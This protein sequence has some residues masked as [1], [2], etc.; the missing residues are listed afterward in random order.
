MAWGA[1]LFLCP[2]VFPSAFPRVPRI[3]TPLRYPLAPRLDTCR[4]QLNL[5]NAGA[6]PL[7]SES[8][9]SDPDLG[10]EIRIDSVG[11]DKTQAEQTLKRMHCSEW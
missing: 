6:P 7:S 5:W 8:G 4:Q 10:V 9:G 3:G 11:T 2:A 1:E